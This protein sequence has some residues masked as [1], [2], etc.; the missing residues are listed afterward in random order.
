[1]KKTK[2]F[3]IAFLLSFMLL[4]NTAFAADNV[5]ETTTATTTSGDVISIQT[6][7][8]SGTIALWGADFFEKSF[9]MNNLFGTDHNAFTVKVSSITQGSCTVEI[10]GD[11]GYYWSSGSFTSDKTFTT[12]NCKSDVTYTVIINANTI[13]G[14]SGKYSITSFIQ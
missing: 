1:M 12:S 9:K 8:S 6:I 5:T 7:N 14:L 10:L 3:I 13:E 4:G 2:Y 11:N